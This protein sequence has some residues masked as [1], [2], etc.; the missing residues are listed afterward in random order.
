MS[1]Q[2]HG[3]I[4]RRTLRDINRFNGIYSVDSDEQQRHEQHRR[5]QPQNFSLIQMEWMKINKIVIL[6]VRTTKR[7][8]FEWLRR[9]RNLSGENPD[10]IVAE[11]PPERKFTI[12]ANDTRILKKLRDEFNRIDGIP[13]QGFFQRGFSW[14]VVK[15]E[16]DGEFYLKSPYHSRGTTLYSKIILRKMRVILND[17]HKE[18]QKRRNAQVIQS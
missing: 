6:Y 11:N 9:K 12:W 5:P 1:E 18:R 13:Q 16:R 2:Q 3:K 4:S 17:L 10:I 7:I 14:A 8:T 15:S